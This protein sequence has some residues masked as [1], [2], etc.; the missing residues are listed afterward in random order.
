MQTI[1]EHASAILT[2]D[3]TAAIDAA[4]RAQSDAHIVLTRE[5]V[6]AM[7]AYLTHRG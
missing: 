1:A 5:Q 6:A 4:I 3:Q 7:V 2:A